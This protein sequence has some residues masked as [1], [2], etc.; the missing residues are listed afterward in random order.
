MFCML[1][2][3]PLTWLGWG[4]LGWAGGE[5]GWATIFRSSSLAAG[6]NTTNRRCVKWWRGR[7]DHSGSVSG[8]TNAGGN[9]VW[10]SIIT[11]LWHLAHFF[12][13]HSGNQCKPETKAPEEHHR[14]IRRNVP[15]ILKCPCL[16]GSILSYV[17]NNTKYLML[18]WRWVMHSIKIRTEFFAK[19][20]WFISC[21]RWKSETMVPQE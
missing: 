5:S 18:K 13:C 3:S 21:F 20:F 7:W 14:C 4:L 8:L 1:P 11:R 12:M 2:Q 10:A 17:H 9:S 16:Q 19:S 6:W 15:G